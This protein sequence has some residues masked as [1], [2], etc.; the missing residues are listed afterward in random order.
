VTTEIRTDALTGAVVAV[1]ASRQSRPNRPVDHCPFCIG[2]IEAPEPYDV[3]AF[4]NRWPSFPD[5]RCEVVLYT[6]EHD[7]T[8]WSIGVDGALKVVDLWAERSAALGGR[9][10]IAYVLVFENRGATVGATIPH[11]HGQIFAYDV[12][13]PAPAAELARAADAGTCSLCAEDP[14]GRLVS[15]AGGWR[16]WVPRA[17]MYPYGL[18]VA[19]VEH[20]PDLP[21][22]TPGS[23]RGLATVLVDVLHRLD[24]LWD[25]PM[26]YMLWFHQRPFDGNGHREAHLHLEIA[27]PLRAPGVQRYVAAGELGSGVY[28]N[29][30]VPE[31][32][33]KEL[34]EVAW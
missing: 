14:G 2:G 27:V 17:S 3:K 33:A 19:P 20:E 1:T 24:A 29:P 10:D 7:A 30:V 16:A 22:L 6:P 23:R 11:P 13:P 21:S 28:V 26:P 32:A 8:F 15:E 18:V 31:A 4:P 34:R 5:E 25:Q 9:D 12:V